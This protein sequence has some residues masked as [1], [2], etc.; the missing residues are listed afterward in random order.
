MTEETTQEQSDFEADLRKLVPSKNALSVE[1]TFYKAGWDAALKASAL[2]KKSQMTV[3]RRV[4]GFTLGLICG[5][6]CAAAGMQ[7]WMP[8]QDQ[9]ED[10][11]VEHEQSVAEDSPK[12]SMPDSPQ[13]AAANSIPPDQ[14]PPTAVAG[15]LGV[16]FAMLSP[17]RWLAAGIPTSEFS[18]TQSRRGWSS[19]TDIDFLMRGLGRHSKPIVVSLPEN[20]TTEVRQ[21]LRAFPAGGNVFDELL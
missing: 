13:P 3:G 15:D 10:A 7:L 21:S 20:E 5:L 11:V 16:V 9:M 17:N 1:E 12:D 2:S 6:A 19:D 4:R 8:A 18:V 14:S